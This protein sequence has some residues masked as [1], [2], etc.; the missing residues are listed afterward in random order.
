MLK[1]LQTNPRPAILLYFGLEYKI[2]SKSGGVYQGG[3][4]AIQPSTW[5]YSIVTGSMRC[6]DRGHTLQGPVWFS[7]GP[8]F[9][10][11]LVIW[12]YRLFKM[13]CPL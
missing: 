5:L 8:P 9:F 11:T 13:T 7:T 3:V 2:K 1:L 4:K 6:P 12:H 10:I